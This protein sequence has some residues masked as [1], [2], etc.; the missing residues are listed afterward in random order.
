MARKFDYF[1]VMVDVSRNSVLKVD[2]FRWYL[3]ILK[4]MGYNCVF[5]LSIYMILKT[6][7]S[8]F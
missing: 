8:G 3:P 4:K 2:T 5:L 1:G 7:N 6:Q